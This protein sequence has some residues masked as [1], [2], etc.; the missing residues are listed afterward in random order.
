M[1]ATLKIATGI[2]GA[3]GLLAVMAIGSQ[4]NAATYVGVDAGTTMNA[5]ASGFALPDGNVFGAKVGTDIG[6]IRAEASVARANLDIAGLASANAIEVGVGAFYDF[7]LSERDALFV[8]VGAKYIEAEI[9][10]FGS[11]ISGD[12]K[13]YSYAVGYSHDFGGW[14]G[15]VSWTRTTADDLEFDGFGSVDL[16]Y[17]VAKVGVRIDLS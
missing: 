16:S 8:G 10:A 11:S 2:A 12:G 13:G 14:T 17:D 3:A 4:A 7:D 6:P 9:D 5:D 15:E 1:G